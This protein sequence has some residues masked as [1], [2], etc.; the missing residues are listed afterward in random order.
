MTDNTF[1]R[2]VSWKSFA[3]TDVGCVRQVNEDSIFEAT[4]KSL[5]AVADGMGGH[6]VGDVASRKIIEV[7][8]TVQPCDR[9]SDYVDAVEDA[10]L[11]ANQELI[12][13]A[14]IMYDNETM[15][16]TI[17][18]FVVVNHVGVCLWVGDSRLYRYRNHQLQQLSRDHSQVAEMVQMG[19]ISEADAETHPHKNVI[20]RAVGVEEQVFVD[21]NVF[22]TQVGD[23]FLLCS[24][25]LYNAVAKEVIEEGLRIRDPEESAL[26][27][28]KQAL[29]NG[30]QDNV[31][32]IVVRAVP[33]SLR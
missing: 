21:I 20:T 16:S 22:S 10:I 17:V 28:M 7:M 18:C 13:Y 30:A 11:R 32:V 19:L 15:G 26:T 14:Q 8:E 9:L 33:G 12:E 24:D 27:L 5:W 25:G 3:L 23:S 1:R 6:E 31:S 4:E 2:P 29:D